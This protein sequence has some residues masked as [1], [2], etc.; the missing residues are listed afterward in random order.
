MDDN[1][2]DDGLLL[3]RLGI[4]DDE[5]SFRKAR[6][7]VDDFANALSDFTANVNLSDALNAVRSFKK[8]WDS[9][10]DKSIELSVKDLTAG[11]YGLTYGS[12]NAIDQLDSQRI[13]GLYGITSEEV[14]RTINAVQAEK[15]ALKYAGQISDDQWRAYSQ[16]AKETGSKTWGG[17]RSGLYKMMTESDNAKVISAFYDELL[18]PLFTK[19]ANAKSTT[20]RDRLLELAQ[21]VMKHTPWASKSMYDYEW[22]TR[23][24]L[25]AQFPIAGLLS[26]G[27]GNSSLLQLEQDIANADRTVHSAAQHMD[28]AKKSWTRVLE[29]IVSP[30]RV[31][32]A[33][34][35]D[36]SASI[37]EWSASLGSIA[38]K[39]G[40]LTAIKSVG[41]D[42]SHNYLALP[43]NKKEAVRFLSDY[44][45]GEYSEFY[46]YYG[47]NGAL[48]DYSSEE[49]M[50]LLDKR[51]QASALNN[52]YIATELSI[53]D[54][55][56]A[57]SPNYRTKE[58]NLA[59]VWAS[60]IM[61]KENVSKEEAKEMMRNP[62]NPY[63]LNTAKQ[64]LS[65]TGT[66]WRM[67]QVGLISEADAWQWLL[68][69]MDKFN[70][71][72]YSK[73]FTN[74]PSVDVNPDKNAI[75]GT[76]NTLDVKI[77]GQKL[78]MDLGESRTYDLTV[79]DLYDVEVE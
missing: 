29:G 13:A 64:N 57:M 34:V 63:Y 37:I 73:V 36:A 5:Q 41:F 27:Q 69:I 62:D 48:V 52:D 45:P 54:R 25:G 44:T 8:L 47:E 33:N 7:E 11:E 55:V 12:K 10:Q 3:L 2:E 18:G 15:G 31:F 14:L 46:G 60:R 9:L 1:D 71:N 51:I 75:K 66:I 16:A 35:L 23:T 17:D 67:G 79:R 77:N 24:E 26:P 39:E 53:F 58:E 61:A 50:H 42:Y 4:E 59:N 76:N 19:A 30:F 38:A 28:Q 21:E 74:L 32:G 56:V 65:Y 43:K 68:T 22:A 70:P 40:S 6:K 20:E 78:K 49:F 72:D